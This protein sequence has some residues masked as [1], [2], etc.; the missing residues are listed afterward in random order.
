MFVSFNLTF[1]P[2]HILGFLGMPRRIYTYHAGLGWDSLNLLVSGAAGVFGLGTGI[3]LVN[4]LLSR[5]GPAR[6]PRNP[7]AADT[8]EWSTSSP[9]PHF[10]FAALPVVE[11]RH[12]LWDQHPLPQ[13]LTGVEPGQEALGAEG[14]L[15]RTTTVTNGMDAQPADTMIVPTD[16]IVPFV[17]AAA[18]ALL[19][20]GLLVDAT[21][22]VALAA[23]ATATA[24]VWW[25]WH[26]EDDLP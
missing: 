9:P 23:A 4:F 17:T 20:V 13:A 2:M 16:T 5:R 8:L 25:T 15:N 1:F 18:L 24:V 7:W 26:T 22:F 3:S 19:F 6:A 11:S 21:V 10:N 12:P 14:A